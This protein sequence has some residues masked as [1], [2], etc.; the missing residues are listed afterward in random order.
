M[1]F[2]ILRPTKVSSPLTHLSFVLHCPMKEVSPVNTNADRKEDHVL[3]T[4]SSPVRVPLLGTDD[5]PSFR[6]GPLEIIVKEDGSGTRGNLSIAEF[7]GTRF[8]I[9]PHKHTEHDENICVL[10]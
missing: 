8:R 9:P 7:R 2:M 6:L 5:G 4:T 3:S 10:E 1:D